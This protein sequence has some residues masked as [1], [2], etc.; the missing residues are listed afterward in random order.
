MAKCITRTMIPGYVS[1][2]TEIGVDNPNTLIG[3]SRQIKDDYRHGGC[4]NL[5]SHE[6]IS[7]D[8]MGRNGR[9]QLSDLEYLQHKYTYECIAIQ[10]PRNLKKW[11]R[12]SSEHTS[13]P[14]CMT[15]ESR[16]ANGLIKLSE[17]EHGSETMPAWNQ[18]CPDHHRDTLATAHQ[19]KLIRKLVIPRAYQ[20]Y[21]HELLM[22]RALDRKVRTQ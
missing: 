7:P 9:T 20:R 3:N 4:L 8:W 12:M 19:V 21:K 22:P 10:D 6:L 14:S 15:R 11:E 13:L 2:G 16:K 18:D 1:T 5:E 17:T